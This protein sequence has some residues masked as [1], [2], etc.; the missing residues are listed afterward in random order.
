[1]TWHRLAGFRAAAPLYHLAEIIQRHTPTSHLYQR[2]HHSAHHITQKTVGGDL[3]T[4]A[5]W[6]RLRHSAL[7]RWHNVVFTSA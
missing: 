7:V 5:P 1:M 3:E 2:S 4:P 6:L